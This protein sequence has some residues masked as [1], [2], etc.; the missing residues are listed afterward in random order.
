[1]IMIGQDGEKV[2]LEK[3]HNACY[4]V[5]AERNSMS[6]FEFFLEVDALRFVDILCKSRMAVRLNQEIQ[7]NG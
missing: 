5:H 3:V 6:P 7:N 4:L 2:Y 1:M